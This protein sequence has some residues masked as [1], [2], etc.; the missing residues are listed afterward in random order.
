MQTS[1]DKAIRTCAGDFDYDAHGHGYAKQRQPDPRIA[2][3]I[4]K[5]LGSS[6][7]VLT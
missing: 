6:R 7:T 2:A 5:A 3:H 1:Y 4:H